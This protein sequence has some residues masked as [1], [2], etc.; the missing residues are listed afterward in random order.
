LPDQAKAI[1]EK[2]T[3][4]SASAQIADEIKIQLG[5][6]TKDED[7]ANLIGSGAQFALAGAPKMIDDAIERTP[8]LVPLKDVIKQFVKSI[9][10]TTK[11]MSV[12][13]KGVITKEM[14]EALK[15]LEKKDD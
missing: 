10:V 7:T 6:S 9:K 5:L 11:D 2:L 8:Q 12:T 14:I 13:F 1:F 3:T 4:I 15:K